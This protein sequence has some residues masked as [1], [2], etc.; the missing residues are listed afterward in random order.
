MRM[1]KGLIC[2]CL[3]CT[4]CFAQVPMDSLSFITVID[5][6]TLTPN[7]VETFYK[8]CTDNAIAGTFACI[9]S[10]GTSYPTIFDY[11][12]QYEKEGFQ[13]T[14]HSHNHQRIYRWQQKMDMTVE[15]VIQVAKGDKYTYKVGDHESPLTVEEILLDSI[16][17]GHICFSYMRKYYPAP[18]TMFGQL[19]RLLGKGDPTITYTNY[20]ISEFRDSALV[21]EDME[22]ALDIFK[23]EGFKDY[24]YFVA[25]YGSQDEDLQDIARRHGL[26]CLVSISN[27]DYLRYDNKYTPF[28]IPRVGFNAADGGISTFDRLKQHI[29]SVSRTGGWLLVGTHIYDGWT[30]EL[31]STRFSD[32]VDYAKERG[33]KFVT[34]KEGF[35]LYSKYSGNKHFPSDSL[36]PDKTAIP[37]VNGMC[38]DLLGRQ[39]DKPRHGV[40]I[41]HMSDGSSRVVIIK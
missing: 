6:D 23:R 21:G 14:L 7:S 5:D 34:L 25:P 40:N 35:E 13:V 1:K 4:T 10:R 41:V 3:L 29:N 8:A 19:M 37:M 9:T 36:N 18:D 15:G 28:N 16:G 17:N 30:E 33:L 2:L 32:F 11:L 22:T 38:Y 20:E 26:K 39:T 27:D 24:D 12:R 31:L